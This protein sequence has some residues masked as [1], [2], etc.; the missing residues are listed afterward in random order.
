MIT[1]LKGAVGVKK[2]MFS[3]MSFEKIKGLYDAEMKKL[4]ENDTAKVEMEKRMKESN[5]F[6]IQKPF[7]DEQETPKKEATLGESLRTLKRT[8]MMAR[9][10][11]TKKPRLVEEE[12]EKGAEEEEAPESSKMQKP[13]STE[14]VKMYMVVMD[15]VPEPISAEPVGVKP[16]EVIHW[17]VMEVDGK[18][19]IRLKRKDE[20]YE[21]YITWNKIVRTCSRS[22]IEEIFEIGMK[23]YA[24][25]L[26]APV[27][28]IKKLVMEYLCMMFKPD[29]VEEIEASCHAEEEAKTM[30]EFWKHLEE[31]LKNLTSLPKSQVRGRLL[32]TEEKLKYGV[33]MP[34][35]Y[36]KGNT[37]LTKRDSENKDLKIQ[38]SSLLEQ[39]NK[40]KDDKDLKK[41]FVCSECISNSKINYRGIIESKDKEIVNLQA[42]LKRSES[43][44]SSS[45]CSKKESMQS[46]LDELRR[47][48]N[49]ACETSDGLRKMNS[50]IFAERNSLKD[51]V[52]CLEVEI[53]MM[54]EKA[55]EDR[56]NTKAQ[57]EMMKIEKERK[58]NLLRN[59][60]TSQEKPLK[61]RNR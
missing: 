52:L 3:K 31:D 59:S 21:V 55:T 18:K 46:E 14:D 34:Y 60:L 9:R 25:E 7:P 37:V 38:N 44:N 13:V 54:K 6:V 11:P 56:N 10:K 30:M 53:N 28:S 61:R 2:E 16:L 17:D 57:D 29:E 39:I 36:E 1:F 51:K 5:D 23:L 47:R 12:A 32:G 40:L 27:I 8:K 24:D 41:D 45:S 48:A 20:K 19:Y 26:K 15:K 35:T 22:D 50:Q 42:K 4:Q 49:I 33:I 58:K 43:I